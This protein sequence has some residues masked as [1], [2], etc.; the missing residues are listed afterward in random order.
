MRVTQTLDLDFTA[1]L[2]AKLIH[3]PLT[4]P[5][6]VTEVEIEEVEMFGSQ[7]TEQELKM[8]FGD[9]YKWIKA[10][11]DSNDWEGSE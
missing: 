5:D 2:S 8:H 4:G 1:H 10:E 6:E 3:D 7:W 11:V 9:L